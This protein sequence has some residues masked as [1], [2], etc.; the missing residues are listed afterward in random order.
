MA[1]VINYNDFKPKNDLSTFGAVK[2]NQKYSFTRVFCDKTIVINTP[3]LEVQFSKTQARDNG[4]AYTFSLSCPKNNEDACKFVDILGRQTNEALIKAAVKNSLSW[5]GDEKDE[6][7]ISENIFKG[8]FY[9]PAEYDPSINFSIADFETEKIHFV[10]INNKIIN[11]INLS[12]KL[13][14]GYRIIVIFAIPSLTVRDGSLRPKVEV[15]SIKVIEHGEP[16]RRPK[17]INEFENKKLKLQDLDTK[18]G[19]DGVKRGKFTKAKY[20]GSS[21]SFRLTGVKL[22]PFA[23]GQESDLGEEGEEKR[24]SYSVSMK[25]EDEDQLN[26]FKKFDKEIRDQLVERS[27]EYYGKSKNLKL[28]NG[29]YNGSYRY[30]KSDKEKIKAG[31]QPEYSPTVNIKFGVWEG[32]FSAKAFNEKNAPIDIDMVQFITNGNAEN[33]CDPRRSYIVDIYMKHIW[34]GTKTSISWE[35]GRIQLM[36]GVESNQ[37]KYLFG[38]EAT[39]ETNAKPKTNNTPITNSDAESAAESAA[40]S[41][42]ENA[43]ENAAES[44]SGAEEDSSEDED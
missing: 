1:S 33:K 20:N 6:E 23:F 42:A 43:A 40:E 19:K 26:F 9:E 44:G 12:D 3:A 18:K 14:D 7:E 15:K 5:F 35:C 31:E 16:S 34:F 30:G 8:L 11:N 25:L 21:P 39:T 10:D 4:T 2:L 38:D 27:K 28:V 36:E 17:D 37:Q 22:A 32:V 24:M 29:L 13:R 41:D